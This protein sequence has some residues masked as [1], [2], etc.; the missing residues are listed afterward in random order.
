MRTRKNGHLPK[1]RKCKILTG[2][3]NLE[4]LRLWGWS[5]NILGYVHK[6]PNN[7]ELLDKR[8]RTTSFSP[9]AYEVTTALPTT[10]TVTTITIK[11]IPTTPNGKTDSLSDERSESQTMSTDLT[12]MK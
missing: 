10:T 11:T 12:G 9:T 3:K 5:N 2:N 4:S 7:T 6:L 8:R 1:R